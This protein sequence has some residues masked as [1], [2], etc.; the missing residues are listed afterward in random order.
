VT[1]AGLR[2][3]IV[4]NMY[5]TADDPAYGAFIATQVESLSRAGAEVQVEF[6]NGRRSATAY[7]GALRS[8][9]RLARPGKFHVVH[10][11]YGLTGFVAAFQRLPLVVTFHGDDLLGTAN[12]HGGVTLKSRLLRRL[13]HVAARRADALVC[14]S[15]AMRQALPRA[16]DRSRAHVLPMGVDTERFSPGD[17]A[18][19]RARLGL[20]P[21]E[22][23][24]LF[25]STPTEP[26]KRLDLA[27][28]GVRRVAA[29]GVAVRLWVVTRVPHDQMPDYFR[30]ADCVI[31][32]SE[33]E[34]G[35]IVVKE[36][37]CCGIPVV[38][39]DVGD[40]RRWL[41]LAPGCRLVERDPAAIAAGLREVLRGPGRVDGDAV[42]REASAER[43]AERLIEV[44][45]EAIARRRG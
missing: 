28:A 37:L 43:V 40:A 29:D 3:L 21:A 45:R 13:S 42:R 19:A 10:A 41:E 22:R 31:V 8:V 16:A 12:G 20:D 17:R 6:V 7:L 24:V 2:V 44:Y 26:V 18:A 23:L 15:E 34:G 33:W 36:A 27:E 25:P 30:A 32:T 5:P 38:S 4:T 39:V 14:Q 1:G 35:P 9:K 11:H